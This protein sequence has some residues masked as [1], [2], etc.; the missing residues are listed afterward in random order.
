MACISEGG[1]LDCGL[2]PLAMTS[3]PSPSAAA[4]P[5]S[6]DADLTC[7]MASPSAEDSAKIQ[8]HTRR[9]HA[10]ERAQ[11]YVEVIAELIATKGEARVVDLAK[12]LG[13]SHVTVARTV[14]RLQR[15]DLVATEPYRSIFLTEKGQALAKTAKMRHDAVVHFL[16]ALGVSPAVAR[17]DAE[18]IEHHVSQETL[19]VMQAFVR[20]RERGA[21]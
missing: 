8:R 3:S 20:S 13:V 11:D 4:Q 12:K 1:R 9:A 5:G 7:L 6:I 14:Q 19:G 2:F 16:I 21:S 17:R 18:G 10:Q 15:E